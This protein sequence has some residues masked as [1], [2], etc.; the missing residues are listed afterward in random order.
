VEAEAKSLYSKHTAYP[1]QKEERIINLK[2]RSTQTFGEQ[3]IKT[4][5]A[6]AQGQLRRYK[7]GM[8]FSPS[9]SRVG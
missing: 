1:R 7:M 8:G 9:L 2:L 3:A 4:V 5:E 6:S